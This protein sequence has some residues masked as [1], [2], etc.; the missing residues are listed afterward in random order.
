MKAWKKLSEQGLGIG[1]MMGEAQE[2]RKLRE[3]KNVWGKRRSIKSAVVTRPGASVGNG[4]QT[5]HE[6]FGLN[7]RSFNADARPR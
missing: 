2:Q 1:Q 6:P 3:D 5:N 7:Y 4:L